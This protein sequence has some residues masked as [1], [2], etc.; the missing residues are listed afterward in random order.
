MNNDEKFPLGGQC[1][2]REAEEFLEITRPVMSPD[3]LAPIPGEIAHEIFRNIQSVAVLLSKARSHEGDPVVLKDEKICGD[4][5]SMAAECLRAI[6]SDILAKP[7]FCRGILD[8]IRASVFRLRA[9]LLLPDSEDSVLHAIE[10]V[11]SAEG[12]D[13]SKMPFAS[14]SSPGRNGEH[15]LPFAYLHLT[16]PVENLEGSSLRLGLVGQMREFE[17]IMERKEEISL[18]E[19]DRTGGG[20][21]WKTLRQE[22]EGLQSRL[23]SPSQYTHEEIAGAC[24]SCK[25]YLM[26]V[27]NAFYLHFHEQH[28]GFDPNWPVLMKWVINTIASISLLRRDLL[29]AL[30][31]EKVKGLLRQ[32]QTFRAG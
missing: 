27:E 18:H 12:I 16:P 22:I 26:R 30:H 24:D 21:D 23:E 10:E 31:P 9:I 2:A 11:A 3:H 29:P 19:L 8:E 6:E 15:L 25:Q 14:E 20:I 7:E 4:A 5:L 13:L 17:K 28:R 32:A 1:A